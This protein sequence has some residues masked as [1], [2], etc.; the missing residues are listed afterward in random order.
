[1]NERQIA[2]LI[3]DKF[4]STNCRAG[5]IVMMR[6]IRFSL[7]EQLNPKEKELFDIVFVGLQITGYFTYEGGAPECI[8]LTQ[9]GYDYIYDD[10]LVPKMLK[11][12]WIIP[13]CVNTDWEKAYNKLW[14]VIGPQ[15]TATC[16]IKGPEFYN[17]VLKFS[18]E[19]P[20]SYGGYIEELRNK[21]LST[22]RVDYYKYL[23]DSIKEEKRLYLYGEVQLLIENR[24]VF[25]Q[26]EI[27]DSFSS[28][29]D[30]ESLNQS[31]STIFVNN[32]VFM[33]T[34]EDHKKDEHPVVF[35]SYSWDG[36]RHEDWVL[37]LAT[38][39][40]SKYGIEI[41]LDKWEMKL[42]KLLPH[43]MEHAITDSQRVICVM[44]P[45]YK[46][47]TENLAGGV[48]VEY[49]IISAE[50]QK[51]IKTE[52]FIPLFRQGEMN[53]IPIFFGGTRFC[54]YERRQ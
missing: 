27:T 30:I 44:T 35:I 6:T 1:M 25:S 28:S 48:G 50:I 33:N 8:R 7:I 43:F 23:I 24:F 36:K 15:D 37:E 53:D 18:D 29:L 11:S 31:S 40:Q 21:D 34:D 5:H 20:P 14:R 47:K 38:D 2:E 49:S 32:E 13:A 22:S 41:I 52:K 26:A 42:G 45:N 3:F 19:L 10:E 9:K 12:P 4:R 16:Y 51:D 39:L 54:G 46:K 17:L